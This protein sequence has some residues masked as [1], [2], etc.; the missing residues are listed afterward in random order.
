[1]N[2]IMKLLAG[3]FLFLVSILGVNQGTTITQ[4]L[5]KLDGVRYLLAERTDTMWLRI[6]TEAG[7]N[8]QL[9]VILTIPGGG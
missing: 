7:L 4:E 9:P 5:R 6:P 8:K 1:M 3:L 2:S